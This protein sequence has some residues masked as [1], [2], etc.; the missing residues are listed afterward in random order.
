MHLFIH[1]VLEINQTTPFFKNGTVIHVGPMINFHT[2]CVSIFCGSQHVNYWN[3]ELGHN[4]TCGSYNNTD[5]SSAIVI[6]H[7]SDVLNLI[8]AQS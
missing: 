2:T 7:G 4:K 1:K 5:I 6:N 3:G 8:S